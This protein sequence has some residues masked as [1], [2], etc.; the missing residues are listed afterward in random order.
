MRIGIDC[1]GV[2][3]QFI[4]SVKRVVSKNYPERAYQLKPEEANW[5]FTSWIPFWTEDQAERYIFKVHFWDIFAN[6]DPFPTAVADYHALNL[7]AKSN[8]HKLVLVSAQRDTT[9]LPT[10]MWLAKHGFDFKEI[11]YTHEK[12]KVPVDVLVD[13]SQAKLRKFN[14]HSVSKGTPIC[15]KRQWNTECWDEFH[16]IDRLIE[17]PTIIK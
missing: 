5:Q 6:A 8:G 13:D 11:H 16:T 12:W 17:L 14:T 3:R 7:W 4:N 9:I 1:D 2:I 10:T 15:F